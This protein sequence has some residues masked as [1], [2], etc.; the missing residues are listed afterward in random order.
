MRM[1]FLLL[2]IMTLQALFADLVSGRDLI[3]F[4]AKG[5]SRVQEV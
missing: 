5:Q 4:P 2:T 3:G 1:T